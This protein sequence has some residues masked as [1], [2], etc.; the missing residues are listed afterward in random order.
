MLQDKVVFITGASGGIGAALAREL[1]AQG[2][3]LVLTA[4]RADKLAA[5]AAELSPRTAVLTVAADVTRDGDLEAAA[6]Q[7]EQAFGA[8][9]VV[10]ANAGFAVGGRFD[11]LTLDDYRRQLET[12][13]FGVLRTVAATLPALKR[14]RGRLGI[15]G[16]I[17][18]YIPAPLSSPYTMSKFAVRALAEALHAE[19]RDEGV[20]VTLLSPGYIVSDIGRVDNQGRWHDEDRSRAPQ[21]LRMPTA[22]AAS[23]IVAAIDARQREAIITTHGKLGIFLYRHFPWL[24]RLAFR[25]GVAQRLTRQR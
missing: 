19:L 17:A 20:A 10:L 6:A 15:V 11:R 14:S 4:R 2:A 23:Q 8:I 5:L 13:V 25:V 24:V 3:R 7:A 16:S 21:W 9:D 18:G 1:A 12:N 22:L